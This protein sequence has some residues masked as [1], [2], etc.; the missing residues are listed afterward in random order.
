MKTVCAFSLKMW[1]P[2]WI[3]IFSILSQDGPDEKKTI[4]TVTI[5]VE[6]CKKVLDELLGHLGGRCVGMRKESSRKQNRIKPSFLV[7]F[8]LDLCSYLHFPGTTL[9][10]GNSYFLSEYIKRQ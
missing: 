1:V 3:S 9:K 4:F 5:H 2:S 6:Q 10:R 8:R 7:I